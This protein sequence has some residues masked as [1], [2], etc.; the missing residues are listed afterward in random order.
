MS[1]ASIASKNKDIKQEKIKKEVKI[2][3]KVNDPYSVL[4]FLDIDDEFEYKYLKNMT[5]IS[6]EFKDF[7]HKNFLPFMDKVSLD[8]KYTVYDFIKNNCEEY[9]KVEKYVINYNNE[10]I[11]DYEKEQEEIEKELAEEEYIS[12]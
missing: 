7:I 1:W 5:N 8:I 6:V 2:V 12:D 11:E 4:N 9:D 3:E 10:L